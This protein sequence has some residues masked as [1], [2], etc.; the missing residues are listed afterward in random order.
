MIRRDE[1]GVALVALEL[2]A[3]ISDADSEQAIALGARDE[4]VIHH[5]SE[6]RESGGR[7]R[8]RK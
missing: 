3:Q 2:S 1:E 7:R 6:L 8:E 4:A 5:G